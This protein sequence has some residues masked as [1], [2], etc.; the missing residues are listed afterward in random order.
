MS[1]GLVLSLNQTIGIREFINDYLEV[2]YTEKGY[3]THYMMEKYLLENGYSLPTRV[4][5][6]DV[7]YEKIISGKVVAVREETKN[8]KKGKILVYENPLKFSDERL[9]FELKEESDYDELAERRRKIMIEDYNTFV[10]FDGEMYKIKKDTEEEV[11]TYSEDNI[12]EYDVND[13]VNRQKVY[14]I[15][16]RRHLV[17][18]RRYL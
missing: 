7:T 13:S 17:D 3:L 4:S 11:E 2:D 8:K 6:K 14:V 18:K 10:N 12:E 16:G 5:Y 9:L 1:N 15:S